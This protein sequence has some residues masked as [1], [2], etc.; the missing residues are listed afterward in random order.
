MANAKPPDLRAIAHSAMKTYGF[1]AAFPNDVISE[2][3]GLNENGRADEGAGAARDMRQLLWSSIDN[4]DSLDLDQLEC[5]QMGSDGEITVFVAIADVDAFVPRHSLTDEHARL[6][7]TSVYTGFET[8]PMLPDRLSHDLTSLI[9]GHERKAVVIE[10]GVLSDGGI[11]NGGIFRALVSNKA[12]LVYEEIGDW[13]QGQSGM[14]DSVARVPGLKE[15]ILLQDQASSRMRG[16]RREA[17]ALE[18]DTIEAKP[19]VRDQS[20][21]D[22]VVI[23]KNRARDIIEN[24]MIAANN[25]MVTFLEKAN[26][27]VIQRVVRT[28]RDWAGIVHQAASCGDRLPAEPDAKALSEFLIRRKEA[29]PQ[30]FPDLSLTIVKLLGAGEYVMLEPEGSHIGHFCLAIMDYTHATAPN[31]RYVD[32]IIQRL[33]KAALDGKP[34]PYTKED[35]EAEA[36]WCSDREKASKKVER[37]MRKA[38]AAVMLRNRVGDTFEAIVTGASEKGIYVRLLTP[39]AEGRVMRHGNG[40]V[41]GMNVRVRLIHLDMMR[42]FIDF[43]GAGRQGTLGKR[44]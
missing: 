26:I 28:P 30:R 4:D 19:I 44:S 39:P 20:V 9:P 33:V 14:P 27:P 36:L 1:V 2:V 23:R 24:F 35:L 21:S 15:Q 29:D 3:K 11:R 13:L 25:T 16:F 40:F 32:L 5:C 17:G 43:E 34:V 31:R 10:F 41:V 22:I 12:K 7:T 42:G 8:F 38:A 18:L 6:N 37:F